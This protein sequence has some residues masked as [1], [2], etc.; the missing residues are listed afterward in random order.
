MFTTGWVGMSALLCRPLVRMLNWHEKWGEVLLLALLG[1]LWGLLYGAIMNL[2]F[3]PYAV[4]SADQYW[5]PGLG[6]VTT[7]QRYA[8]FYVVTSL[9]WDG[10]RAIGNVLMLLAFG[11]AILRVLRRFHARFAFTYAPLTPLPKA[12]E[13]PVYQPTTRTATPLEQP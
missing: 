9:A 10:M 13:K 3:W 5:T 4:G 2:W 1:G 11:G 8:L 6:L 12:A 7:L